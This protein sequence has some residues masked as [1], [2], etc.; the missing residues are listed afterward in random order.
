M[1]PLAARGRAAREGMH[2][3]VRVQVHV[4]GRGAIRSGASMGDYTYKA[5]AP[6]RG[7]ARES[8]RRHKRVRGAPLLWR[9]C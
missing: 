7:A 5:S 4:C 8:S 1:R 6:C 3:R 9:A 2:V